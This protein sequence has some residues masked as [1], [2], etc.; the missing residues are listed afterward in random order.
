MTNSWIRL[1]IFLL[2]TIFKISLVIL[3]TLILYIIWL[4]K[5]L[6]DP[7][8]GLD[9]K[10]E[11]DKLIAENKCESVVDVVWRLALTSDTDS[12]VMYKFSFINQILQTPCKEQ[13]LANGYIKFILDD[14]ERYKNFLLDTKHTNLWG[15]VLGRNNLIEL[16][17]LI[18]NK[19]V[20][21]T[22]NFNFPRLNFY[23]HCNIA[24]GFSDDS[25]YYHIRRILAKAH[26]SDPEDFDTRDTSYLIP[27]WEEREYKTC[28]VSGIYLE[29]F[30]SEE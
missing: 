1:P 21:R 22:I 8:E 29:D 5:P 16:P 23:L 18:F 13:L 7:R 6:P 24:L 3:I 9:L 19:K 10:M 25:N 15:P 20:R 27:A 26:C 11:I 12:D 2:K 17:K 28:Y 30:A 14:Q 4:T